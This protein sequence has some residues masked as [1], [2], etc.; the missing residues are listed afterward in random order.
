M[1]G[2]VMTRQER[3]NVI[4]TA[5][6]HRRL[7]NETARRQFDLNANDLRARSHWLTQTAAM[8]SRPSRVL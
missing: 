4:R 1:E 7:I 3:L 2:I 5:A 8:M 6:E